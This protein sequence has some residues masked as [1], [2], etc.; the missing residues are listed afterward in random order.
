MKQSLSGSMHIEKEG[1][2][3]DFFKSTFENLRGGDFPYALVIFERDGSVSSLRAPED[4][5]G[6]E[7]LE[8]V[9]LALD[10]VH[11]AIARAD[12]MMEYL[13]HEKTAAREL[14]ANKEKDDRPKLVLIQG[15]LEENDSEI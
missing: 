2:D 6:E 4:L 8:S 15:G 5:I 3:E 11:Y 12:W 9:T 13:A 7:D 14:E 10:F 1:S